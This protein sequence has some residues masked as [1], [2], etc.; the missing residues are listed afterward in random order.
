MKGI[1]SLLRTAKLSHAAI[2]RGLPFFVEKPLATNWP[3]AAPII[4]YMPQQ[5]KF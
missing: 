3:T 2:E 5:R 1:V 4:H